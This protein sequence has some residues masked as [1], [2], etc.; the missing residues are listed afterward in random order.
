MSPEDEVRA[1]LLLLD[2]SMPAAVSLLTG[3]SGSELDELG[4]FQINDENSVSP[5]R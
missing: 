5:S 3:M 4:G 1:A 2:G